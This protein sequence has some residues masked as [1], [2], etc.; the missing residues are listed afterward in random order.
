MI[1]PLKKL[2]EYDNFKIKINNLIVWIEWHEWMNK[3]NFVNKVMEIIE[4]FEEM[5]I[6][7]NYNEDGV[8]LTYLIVGG[9]NDNSIEL[10]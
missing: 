10:Y 6:E 4:E 1:I 8:E 2:F 5:P 9:I 3:T 7:I